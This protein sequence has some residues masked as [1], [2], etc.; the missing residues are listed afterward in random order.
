MNYKS[1]MIPKL[2]LA[3]KDH[4]SYD[5]SNALR[6]LI[7]AYANL[8][9][10]EDPP[11]FGVSSIVCIQEALGALGQLYRRIALDPKTPRDVQSEVYEK[12]NRCYDLRHGFN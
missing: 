1:E 9:E 8:R 12:S 5:V 4:E 7:I 3:L 6:H 11:V 2:P 10:E